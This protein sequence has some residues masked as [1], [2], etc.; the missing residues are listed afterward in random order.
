[1]KKQLGGSSKQETEN[2][3]VNYYN[4]QLFIKILEEN[5][6]MP[7]DRSE[8]SKDAGPKSVHVP[9]SDILI[10]MSYHMEYMR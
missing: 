5:N 9:F 2:T 10:L 8:F 6:V 4:P 7:L 1:L 3:N